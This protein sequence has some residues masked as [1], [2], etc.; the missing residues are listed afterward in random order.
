MGALLERAIRK[1]ELIVAGVGEDR[2]TGDCPLCQTFLRGGDRNCNG[3]PVR[4][5][6]GLSG[7]A[8]TPYEAFAA[9]DEQ[10]AKEVHEAGYADTDELRALARAELD[11]LRSL[12]PHDD[13]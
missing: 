1:W 7:C 3:C 13:H 2:A 6:T 8:G 9:L 11:F 10:E 12:L 4:K 5:A